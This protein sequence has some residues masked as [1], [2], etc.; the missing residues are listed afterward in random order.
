M[1]TL[2]REM[3]TTDTY[4]FSKYG[5]TV[6]ADI[7]PSPSPEPRADEVVRKY[8]ALLLANETGTHAT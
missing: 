8:K 3:L 6:Y 7:E 1:L 5:H 4:A 2:I